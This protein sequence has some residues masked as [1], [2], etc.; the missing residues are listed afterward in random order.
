MNDLITKKEHLKKA[1]AN[2]EEFIEGYK[3]TPKKSI[4]SGVIYGFEL[5][6]EFSW[7]AL[8][9]YLE[10]QGFLILGG[11]K[12]ILKEAYANNIID[13]EKVWLAILDDIKLIY[14]YYD[15][16]TA[17]KIFLRIKNDYLPVFKKLSKS[18][19]KEW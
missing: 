12:S 18:L 15:E 4:Q 7:Q 19:D 5:C 2:L 14:Y 1:I 6:F 3:A 8:R 16:D 11:P 9:M 10:D 13:D 17:N